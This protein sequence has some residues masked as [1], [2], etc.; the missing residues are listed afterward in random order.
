M[1]TWVILVIIISA[2]I[3]HSSILGAHFY[4]H[5]TIRTFWA[6][7]D[8]MFMYPVIGYKITYF[9]FIRTDPQIKTVISIKFIL[10]WKS[11]CR[12]E[13]IETAIIE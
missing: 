1:G 8:I 3:K 13:Q 10:E 2:S 11:A 5:I 4:Y 7:K 6:F 12:T 9:R